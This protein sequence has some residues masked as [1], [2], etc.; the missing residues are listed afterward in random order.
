MVT[1]RTKEGLMVAAIYRKEEQF[2]LAQ[3]CKGAIPTKKINPIDPR[4]VVYEITQDRVSSS[5]DFRFYFWKGYKIVIS[6][7][8]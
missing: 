3:I 5:G 7:K 2:L 1:I 6:D 8:H 4:Y